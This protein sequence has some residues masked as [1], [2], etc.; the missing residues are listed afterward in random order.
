MDPLIPS[1]WYALL[2]L[3]G[4]LGLK[5]G[6]DADHLATIDGLT[7]Y[8][9]ALGRRV[10]RYCGSLFSLG[11]GGAVLL[12][13]LAVSGLPSLG[14]VPSWFGWL[15][16]LISIAFLVA[17]GLL[18]LRAV[19]RT[20]ANQSV[21]PVGLKGRWLGS[22]QRASHPALIAL[23]GVLF[24]LSFDTLSLAAFFALAASHFGGWPHALALGL[25]FTL[26]V[27]VTDGLNGLWIAR[28]LAR[29]DQ[30]GR[31]ASRWLGLAV[32]FLSLLVALLGT[33]RLLWPELDAWAT[34]RDLALGL[35]LLLAV[36]GAYAVAQY[37]GR[38][39]DQAKP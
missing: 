12:I 20:P 39:R 2:T 13:A 6:F 14:Q 38:G 28:L 4:V 26:G 35:L 19:L 36:L 8:N 11:H 25:T 23:V 15:G 7:R 33:L 37:R 3:A 1:D 29:A 5:H 34:Q 16:A 24:A 30:T 9:S 22:L 21:R 27:V 32:A 31:T 18:N 10:A 17:L